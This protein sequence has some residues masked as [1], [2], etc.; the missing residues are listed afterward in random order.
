MAALQ[1][2]FEW[3]SFV[4]RWQQ[5]GLPVPAFGIGL[6]TGNGILGNF[7]GDGRFVYNFLGSSLEYSETLQELNKHYGSRILMSESMYLIVQD[8]PKLLIREMDTIEFMEDQPSVVVYELLGTP[9]SQHPLADIINWYEQ[10][11]SFYRQRNFQE[12]IRYFQEITRIRPNDGP[13]Q[14]MLKRSE[15]FLQYPPNFQWDGAWKLP[16]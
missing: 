2:Q 1:M 13:A 9:N 3:D 10:G 12:A 6:D 5:E 11:L 4:P 8:N 7:G 15:K 14:T 16:S